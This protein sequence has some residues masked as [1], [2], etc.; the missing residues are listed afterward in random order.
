MALAMLVRGVI[1]DVERLGLK[2]AFEMF[3]LRRNRPPIAIP[4]RDV[5]APQDFVPAP[6]DVAQIAVL[7]PHSQR[8]GAQ[9]FAIV[10]AVVFIVVFIHALV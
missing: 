6:F 9:F 2:L 5:N 1:D 10:F 3:D 4:N 8:P 7:K